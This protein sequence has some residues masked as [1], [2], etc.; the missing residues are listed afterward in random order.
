MRFLARRVSFRDRLGRKTHFPSHLSP[1]LS[2]SFS[3]HPTTALAEFDQLLREELEKV[4]R[5]YADREAELEVR[6]EP[7]KSVLIFPSFAPFRSRHNALG[8]VPL[9]S[10]PTPS[11]LTPALSRPFLF[12]FF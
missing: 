12:S 3:K 7:P 5:F 11:F 10:F 8:R 1:P 4:D 9:P 2:P 6:A